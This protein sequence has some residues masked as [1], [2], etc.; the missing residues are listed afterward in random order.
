[1]S[2]GRKIIFVIALMVFVGALGA[3]VNHYVTG[4]RAEKALTDLGELKTEQEDLVTD[5][6]VVIGKYVNLYKKIRTLSDGLPWTE[7]ILII[8]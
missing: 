5:K 4:W 8:R 1:M 6:G 7:P 2:L 3:I